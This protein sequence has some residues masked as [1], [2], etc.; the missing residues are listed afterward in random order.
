MGGTQ[1]KHMPEMPSTPRCQRAHGAGIGGLSHVSGMDNAVRIL[2]S[3]WLLT[4]RELDELKDRPS[5]W[6]E[7][8]G[9]GGQFIGVYMTPLHD[10]RPTVLYSRD[11][12]VV[13]IFSLALLERPDY[14]MNLRDQNGYLT[15]KS[16]AP[17]MLWEVY[18]DPEEKV[19]YEL[20]W[21]NPEVVF[22]NPVSLEYM[23]RI[24]VKQD[25]YDNFVKKLRNGLTPE[26]VEQVMPLL[27]VY[28]SKSIPARHCNLHC[29]K[30]NRWAYR[31]RFCAVYGHDIKKLSKHDADRILP[32]WDAL[33]KLALNCGIP[34]SEIKGLTRKGLNRESYGELQGRIHEKE[35]EMIYDKAKI[36]APKYLPPL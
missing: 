26:Q 36:I 8:T 25:E 17:D 16:Y 31:P 10:D 21:H 7:G 11:T 12:E 35:R 22:H 32:N 15:H 13:F 33:F 1:G 18:Q 34:E 24:Y 9:V 3:G 23:Q 28:D 4:G 2:R 27:R 6:T 20:Q 30:N 5:G 29:D 14:H 19:P